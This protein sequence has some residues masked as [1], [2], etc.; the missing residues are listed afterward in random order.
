[1]R[2]G[3][4]EVMTYDNENEVI[5]ETFES[6]LSRY[7]IR[8]EAS[9]KSSNLSFDVVNLLYYKCHNINFKSGG[10]YIESPDRM[11]NK[12]VTINLNIPK[13]K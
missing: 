2:S 6:L 12:K 3:N 13:Y 1:M 9:T 4:I 8:L 5:K 7:K 10:S 11:K